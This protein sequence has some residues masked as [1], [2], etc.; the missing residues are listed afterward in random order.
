M[1]KIIFILFTI[2]IA[3]GCAQYSVKP[4]VPGKQE[5]I[6]FAL[7]EEELK[8]YVDIA[9]AIHEEPDFY[10]DDLSDYYVYLGPKDLDSSL[11][12]EDDVKFVETERVDRFVK[13]F[14]RYKK[15][16]NKWIPRAER[17][18]YI[19][20]DIFRHEGVPEELVYLGLAESGF[21]PHAVSRAGATGIW[22][23]MKGTGQIYGLSVNFWVDER[24]CY[25]KS[26]LAAAKHLEDLHERLGDWYLA[27]AAYNAGLGKVLK[28]MKMYKSDDFFYISKRRYLKP[29][30]RNYVPKYLALRHI[31]RNYDKYGFEIGEVEPLL[32][33]KVKLDKQVN[34]FVVA[35]II[36][37]DVD[38]LFDLNPELLTPITPSP[39][40]YNRYKYKYAEKIDYYELKVPLGKGEKLQLAIENMHPDKLRQVRT[41][42]ARKGSKVY[43]IAKKAGMSKSSFQKFNNVKHNVFLR[44]EPVFV[45][46]KKYYDPKLNKDFGKHVN[47]FNPRVHIVRRG[48]SLSVIARYYG[49]STRHIRALNRR[50]HP[51]RL[52]PGMALVISRGGCSGGKCVSKLRTSLAPKTVYKKKVKRRKYTKKTTHTVKAGESLWQITRKYDILVEEIKK[53]NG[54]KSNYIKPG[55]SLTVYY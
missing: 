12:H 21:N 50:V 39:A 31:Y 34:L 8:L 6:N 54:L 14:T 18:L 41:I 29:E 38:E 49:L 19:A 20:K 40:L 16:M 30:T 4:E 27:M 2:Y 23:F 10:D 36:D 24:K 7:L 33:D 22:Q 51:R 25:E 5:K 55:D 52:R 35:D 13:R 1:K 47:R 46:I 45:P 32:Y 48:E 17:Y 37:V 9:E 11:S 3:A 26:T 43:S 44:T 15:T 42:I 28:A 53:W